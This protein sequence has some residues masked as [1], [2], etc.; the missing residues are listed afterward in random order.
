MPMTF[1]IA[2]LTPKKDGLVGHAMARMQGQRYRVHSL[3]LS[4]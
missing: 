2:A 3:R 1:D 4:K